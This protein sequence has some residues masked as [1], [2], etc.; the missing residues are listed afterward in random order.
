M[1]TKSFYRFRIGI[2][3][4]Y[5]IIDKADYVLKKFNESEQKILQEV[6]NEFKKT[7]DDINPETMSELES[8]RSISEL[9]GFWSNSY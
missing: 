2:S 9:F 6:F 4:K 1:K 5:K 3:P 8:K 7:I